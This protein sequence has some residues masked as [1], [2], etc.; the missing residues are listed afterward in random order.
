MQAVII[1]ILC[2]GFGLSVLMLRCLIGGRFIESISEHLL[3]YSLLGT[4]IGG[5]STLCLQ[6]LNYG[7]DGYPLFNKISWIVF[8][9]SVGCQIIS[10]VLDEENRMR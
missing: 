8:G 6:F 1:I 9:V 4:A 3:L 7:L 5:L 10:L 2:S